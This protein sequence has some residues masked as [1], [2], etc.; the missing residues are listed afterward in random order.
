M[1]KVN[2]EKALRSYLLGRLSGDDRERLEKR[3]LADEDYFQ[4][5]LFLEEELIDE[6]LAGELTAEERERFD[7]YFLSAPER[8]QQLRFAK[9]FRKY[10]VSAAVNRAPEAAVGARRSALQAFFLSL[11]P[12]RPAFL[13]A[14][15]ALLAIVIGGFWLIRRRSQPAP[16][17]TRN[18]PAS[19]TPAPQ[20]GPTTNL[21]GGEIVAQATPAPVNNNAK[22]GLAPTPPPR[23]ESPKSVVVPVTLASGLVR[24]DG[25]WKRVKVSPDIS[26]VRLQLELDASSDNYQSYR[27]V[28]Q[29]ASGREVLTRSGL[30]AGG[31]ARGKTITLDVPARLLKRDDYYLRLSGQNPEKEFEAAGSYSFRVIE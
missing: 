7:S 16:V 9:A 10:A 13:F 26:I 28:L 15:A 22:P 6:Y 4:Q 5:L 23:N 3:L 29:S 21:N 2:E 19:P 30:R 17:M 1:L 27:A 24:G 25:D 18:E 20:P 12:S 8:Q 14:L 11:R 31:G